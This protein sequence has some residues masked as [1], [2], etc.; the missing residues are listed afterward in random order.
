MLAHMVEDA[1]DFGFDEHPGF[2]G[3]LAEGPDVLGSGL[4]GFHLV[5][6]PY[7]DGNGLVFG[8]IG[9]GFSDVE[10][11]GVGC[12]VEHGAVGFGEVF[13]GDEIVLVEECSQAA[14][15]EGAEKFDGD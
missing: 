8:G 5:F 11:G 4:P 12:G 7:V 2:A 3:V 9:C 15:V 13:D 10:D 1:A 6:S 14:A